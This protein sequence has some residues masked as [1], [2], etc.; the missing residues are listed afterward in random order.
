M[1]FQEAQYIIN[2]FPRL[3]NKTEL[4]ARWHDF[5]MLKLR[6]PDT[7]ENPKSYYRR[8]KRFEANNL[9]SNDPDVLK[10]LE[11][12]YEAFAIETAQ[13]IQR[14]TPNQFKVNRCPNCNVIARTPY[15]KQC[16]ICKHDWHNEIA[17]AFL[18]ESAFRITGRPYLW[19]VGECSRGHIDIGCKIDLTFFQLNIVKE[20]KQIEL[21][22]K[23]INGEKKELPSLGIAVNDKE[24]KLIKEYLKPSAKAIMILK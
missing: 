5:Y 8:K 7:Y 13:R 12:G 15:A 2:Y 24:E 18:F 20:I 9:I 14:D 11:N 17:A 3:M 10:L 19:I 6:T 16:S 23:S 22:L 1:K 21:C 4:K